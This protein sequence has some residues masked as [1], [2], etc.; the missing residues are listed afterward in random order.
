MTDTR[1]IGQCVFL[2]DSTVSVHTTSALLRSGI[3]E[4]AEGAQ[5]CLRGMMG[6]PPLCGEVSLAGAAPLPAGL[7]RSLPAP[8]AARLL[9]GCVRGCVGCSSTSAAALCR[10]GW[11]RVPSTRGWQRAATPAGL[12]FRKALGTYLHLL[13]TP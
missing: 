4:G 5:K 8:A 2:S 1:I 6:E 13:E 11:D 10:A 3:A 9:Q 7:F 12:P